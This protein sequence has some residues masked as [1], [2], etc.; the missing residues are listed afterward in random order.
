MQ[1]NISLTQVSKIQL[2][3]YLLFFFLKKIIIADRNT[4]VCQKQGLQWAYLT[5]IY[6]TALLSQASKVLFRL[7]GN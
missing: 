4:E 2:I 6:V 5:V 7:V 1:E 3:F